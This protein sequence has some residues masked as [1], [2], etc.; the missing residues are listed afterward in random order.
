MWSF[1]GFGLFVTYWLLW[2]VLM[3]CYGVSSCLLLLVV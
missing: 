3:A 1:A 2:V